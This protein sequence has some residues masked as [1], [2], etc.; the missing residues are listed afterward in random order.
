MGEALVVTIH[1]YLS[2]AIFLASPSLGFWFVMRAARP[3]L[4]SSPPHAPMVRQ[5]PH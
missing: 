3:Q 2:A 5:D 4:A 1:A